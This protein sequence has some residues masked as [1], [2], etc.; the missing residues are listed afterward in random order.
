MR[1]I[2]KISR[3][4]LAAILVPQC[5]CCRRTHQLP[6]RLCTACLTSLKSN[7]CPR[8]LRLS[9]E[10]VADRTN[11]ETHYSVP[12]AQTVAGISHLQSV[13][14]YRDVVPDL[15]IGWKYNGMVELTDIIA[16]WETHNCEVSYSY[17]LVTIIPCHW[18][19]RLIRGFDHIWLLANALAK[20]G[21]I[22]T[23]V[24]TLQH[25]K[26]L[27]FLHLQ[28]AS[29]RHI[30]PDHFRTVRSV[31]DKRI[32]IIDDVITSGATLSAAAAVLKREGALEVSALTVATFREVLLPAS[33][34]RV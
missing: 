24:K 9:V 26:P 6:E 28:A 8:P 3:R 32:L 15:L 21:L 33:R 23:P 2:R 14:Y 13:F 19:R 27:P 12:R 34:T 10:R 31:K 25:S 4:A 18:R 11:I 17:D 7:L 16:Y 5:A 29:D 22:Q 20:Q 30:D 1:S